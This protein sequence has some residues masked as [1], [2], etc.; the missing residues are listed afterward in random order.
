MASHPHFIWK[1]LFRTGDSEKRSI[2]ETLRENILFRTLNRRELS[3]LSNFVYER[4]YQTDE[5]VFQQNDRGIG[6]YIIS[7]GRV[8]IRT[9]SPQGDTLVTVLEEGSFFGEIALVEPDN[10]RTASAVPLERTVLVGFFKP[11]LMEILER[12]PDMGVKILFQLCTVIG[13]RLME[14]TERISMMKRAQPAV[15]A[16]PPAK[17]RHEDAV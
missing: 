15:H 9:Q 14:T 7:K 6:M 12:K 8:S 13:R 1:D 10:I 11:D 17:A 16:A 4:V 3:Y 5:P 2:I